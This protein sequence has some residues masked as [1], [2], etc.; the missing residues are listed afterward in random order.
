MNLQ[1]LNSYA[2]AKGWRVELYVEAIDEVVNLV[3]YKVG[4]V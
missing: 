3:E 2:A 4:G 1:E